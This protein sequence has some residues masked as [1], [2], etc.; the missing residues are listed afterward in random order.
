MHLSYIGGMTDWISALTEI[1]D[2]LSSE[3]AMAWFI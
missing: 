3:T 1:L 2:G